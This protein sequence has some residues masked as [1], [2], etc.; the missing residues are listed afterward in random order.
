MRLR[1]FI[2]DERSIG[3][4]VL[5]M[6]VAFDVE[7]RGDPKCQHRG[8][9][10]SS[11]P[12]TGYNRLIIQDEIRYKTPIRRTIECITGRSSSLDRR[13]QITTSAETRPANRSGLE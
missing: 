8:A 2:I 3:Q 5:E 7:G 11:L 10:K 4:L 13:Y 1:Q 9:C 6:L 12:E